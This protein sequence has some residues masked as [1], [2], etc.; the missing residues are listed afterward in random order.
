VTSGTVSRI[1]AERRG[2]G[3]LPAAS[4]P[5]PWGLWGVELGVLLELAW[6]CPVAELFHQ[7]GAPRDAEEFHCVGGGFEEP[8]FEQN[9]EADAFAPTASPVDPGKA[10]V[11]TG[12]PRDGEHLHISFPQSSAQDPLVDVNS[13]EMP[14][15]API[16]LSHHTLK[17]LNIRLVCHATRLYFFVCNPLHFTGAAAAD[18]QSL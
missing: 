14:R 9:D 17:S 6:F 2:C 16:K 15:G 12:V 13:M 5:L 11:G 1:S 8:A 7:W 18:R 10:P 3:R 4:R